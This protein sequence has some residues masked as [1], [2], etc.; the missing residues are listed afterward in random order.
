MRSN[1]I[2]DNPNI[3]PISNQNNL[4]S[5]ESSQGKANVEKKISRIS[6]AFIHGFRRMRESYTENSTLSGFY[7]YEGDSMDYK[8]LFAKI[9]KLTLR[10]LLLF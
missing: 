10:Y 9:K 6:Q 3:S 5:N 1:S 8:L 4:T 2:Q 7:Y